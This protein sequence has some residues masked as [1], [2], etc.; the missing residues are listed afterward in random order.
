MNFNDFK[1]RFGSLDI[2]IN[3]NRNEERRRELNRKKFEQERRIREINET[4]S[5]VKSQSIF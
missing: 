3:V 2:H 1:L 4:R 5:Q